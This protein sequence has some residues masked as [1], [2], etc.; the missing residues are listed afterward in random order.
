MICRVIQMI[1]LFDRQKNGS[2]HYDAP[3]L[4]NGEVN[5]VLDGIMITPV[6]SSPVFTIH[7]DRTVTEA[8]EIMLNHSISGLPVL[9][10]DG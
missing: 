10:H 4:D 3:L 1:C 8:A 6:M 2:T 7:S 5:S 9:N